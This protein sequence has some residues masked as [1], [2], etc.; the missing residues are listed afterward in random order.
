[1]GRGFNQSF[2]QNRYCYI[3]FGCRYAHYEMKSAENRNFEGV[4]PILAGN[5]SVMTS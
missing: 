5:P 2:E 3:E 1:M 4:S